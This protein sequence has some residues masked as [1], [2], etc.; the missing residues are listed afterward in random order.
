M[1]YAIEYMQYFYRPQTKFA[2]VMFSQVSVCPPWG[3]GGCGRGACMAVVGGHAWHRGVWQWGMACVTRGACMD[4]RGCVWWGGHV[5][6]GGVYG[7]G[8][9]MALMS[10]PSGYY[11]I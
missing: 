10:P 5:W 11:E 8:A 4:G 2:K 6:K 1:K 7:G 9:C 3:G